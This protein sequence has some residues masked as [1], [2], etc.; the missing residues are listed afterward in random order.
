MLMRTFF[1]RRWLGAAAT[2]AFL[3]VA[4]AFAQSSCNFPVFPEAVVLGQYSFTGAVGDEATYAVDAQPTN[5]T[6]SPMRRGAGV[7]PSVGANAFSGTNWTVASA[8]DTAQYYA[9]RLTA[10][11]GQSLDLDS[12]VF[13]ERRSL[14]GVGAWQVRSSVDGFTSVVAGDSVPDDNTFRT[15]PIALGGAF[16]GISTVE[17]RLYGFSAEAA[18]GTWRI[19]NV[20]L[21]GTIGGVVVTTPT[22]Q[23]STAASSVSEADSTASVLVSLTNPSATVATTVQLSLATAPGTATGGADYTFLPATRTLTFAAGSSTA[24]R[25]EVPILEDTLVEGAETI[26]FT[27]TNVSAGAAI[28]T[29]NSLTITIQDNDSTTNPN[30]QTPP[31]ETIAAVTPNDTAG[32]AV[33][34]TQVVR[35][36]GIVTGPN[37]R[38]TGY[39]V[40]LQDAT[41]G[42]TLFGFAPI[43]SITIAPGDEIEV[44]GRIDQFNGLTE[45]IPDSIF[46][47]G[48]GRALPA[49]RTVTVL[50]EATES[51]VVRIAGP[52]TIPN[53]AQWT[54]MGSGFNVD[55]TDG[56]TTYT[57]RVVR[58][59][60]LYGTAAPTAP[61]S[62]IGVGG[63]F[64]NA[65]PFFEGYQILPRFLTDIVT[66]TTTNPTTATV[67]FSAATA[68]ATES[69]NTVSV[70]VTLLNA[71]SA[72]TTTVQV[73]F[74]SAST[75][76]RPADF[77]LDSAAQTLSFAPS[78]TSQILT[79]TLVDDAVVEGSETVVLRLVAPTGVTLGTPSMYTLT[80]SDNDST[81]GLTPPLRTIAS[82]V[83]TDAQGVA[84]LDGQAVRVRGIVTSPNVRTTGYSV[85]LQDSSDRGIT[86]F[87]SMPLGTQTLTQGD[88]VEVV[89]LIDQFNGLAE[90]I[91]DSFR[92][93]RTGQTVPAPRVVTVLDE[94]TESVLVKINGPLT[95]PNPTQWT[96]MGSGFTVDV[97]DGTTT[98]AMRIVRGSGLYG[99]AVPTGQF[100][101]TGTG[102][103]FDASAPYAEGYQILPRT[104]ADIEAVVGR[105]DDLAAA[106]VAL[107]P[108]PATDR[109]T[110]QAPATATAAVVIDALG[111]TVLTAKLAA[112]GT[113]TFAVQ[114]LPAG[115]YSVRV[116]GGSLGATSAVRRFVKQ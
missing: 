11:T 41:G 19:D 21:V 82:A 74:D 59:T 23:F 28:G 56:T 84:I 83:A 60:A 107:Y 17:F 70:T 1:S 92:I 87:R 34:L 105:A 33:R 7:T 25:I 115:I 50:S 94:T 102:G 65:A 49:P 55:V 30:P 29:P 110:V 24:Q 62:L 51:E 106:T 79:L 91:P 69:N 98:Y 61:F 95:I 46:V 36:R 8:P 54:N 53:P 35:V 5:G 2:M 3:A 12:L 80:I 26:I 32:V 22:V 14:T 48:T 104:T 90:I 100:R 108:N 96:N 76:T 10:A 47:R 6:F 37:T 13:S 101:L 44:V 27:L 64:D 112:D 63:Q 73:L 68:T 40:S 45:I 4:P 58:G 57:L 43:D 38:T 9:F 111:R 88:E 86:I 103:Q 75:A 67:Q 97:T 71:D 39:S 66:D 31:L 42:I 109:L 99:T 15:H 78:I 77:T 81:V 113:A 72:A 16:A 89:G 18:P 116:S 114:A 52:L 20:R 93:R 85:T